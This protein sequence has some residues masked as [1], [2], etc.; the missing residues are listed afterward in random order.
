M[1]A[2]YRLDDAIQL[3]GRRFTQDELLVID[4]KVKTHYDEGRT[5]ISRKICEELNWRQ[6]NGWLKD[7][8]CREVL[9]KLSQRGM[10]VLPKSRK[11]VKA[12]PE[13]QESKLKV[14]PIEE[15]EIGNVEFN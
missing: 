5:V 3:R 15:I 7:R 9:V 10:I 4:N 8:A 12:T 13:I 14:S 11:H 2:D 1:L 6:P